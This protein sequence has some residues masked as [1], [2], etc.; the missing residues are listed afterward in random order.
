MK[1][2]KS[3]Y[4]ELYEFKDIED[5]LK[6]IYYKISFENRIFGYLI[7]EKS[8]DLILRK[9]YIKERFRNS[10]YGS[11]LLNYAIYDSADII[12]VEKIVVE[13]Y[14]NLNNFLEKNDFFNI[15]G[16]YVRKGFEDEINN[17]KVTIK[18][19]K[20][21]I[22]INI[23]LAFFK[24][25]LGYTFKI[26]SLI[27]DGI[28]SFSDLINN[29]LILVGASIGKEPYDEDHPFGHGKIETVF[30]LIIGVIIVISSLNVMKNSIISLVNKHYFI[31]SEKYNLILGISIIM[32]ILKILQYIYVYGYSKKYTNSL[33]K[34]LLLDYNFDIILS[35]TVFIGLLG[36]KF[37]DPSL[38]SI[39]SILITIYLI[40]QGYENIKEN[41]LMLMDSQDENLLLKV[42][43][44][45]LEIEEIKNIHDIYMTRVGN[46]VYIIADIRLDE[47]LTLREAHKIS[48]RAERHV[49]FRC[50]NIK[51]VI[52]HIEPIYSEE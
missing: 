4:C 45:T 7:F 42:K 51:K 34:S 43:L 23:L 47:N 35:S 46:N 18:V 52:Y 14:K 9:I 27:A 6:Y 50:S 36:A 11:K 22:F 26:N 1:I 5:S 3:S 8:E 38:D 24:L 25:F 2:E 37:L 44:L 29:I 30:S 48:E 41:T 33:I 13:E 49:K 19:S 39:L 21:S 10:G 31:I 40:K 20:I 32:I 28:N 17:L 15:N 16:K 12:G